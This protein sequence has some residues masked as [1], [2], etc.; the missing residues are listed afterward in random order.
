MKKQVIIFIKTLSILSILIIIS[1][2]P[3]N[4]SSTPK[5]SDNTITTQA[6]IST[7]EYKKE[8][9]QL[10]NSQDD[11]LA[12]QEK[13]YPIKVGS[14]QFQ[15]LEDGSKKIVKDSKFGFINKEG[16]MKIPPIYDIANNFS[17]ELALV[18]KDTRWG[19]IDKKSNIIIDMENAVSCR[20]FSEG[21]AC[22]IDSIS[23]LYG[24]I[25]NNGATVIEPK[26][27]Y[28]GDFHDGLSLVC[29]GQGNEQYFFYIDSRGNDVFNKIYDKYATS[30]ENGFAVNRKTVNDQVIRYVLDTNGNE[31][32][33]PE[34][35]SISGD[36]VLYN[37]TIQ[38]KN[39]TDG[40]S[41]FW[42]L[43]DGS[44]TSVNKNN[45]NNEGGDNPPI[46]LT[47]YRILNPDSDHII[48]QDLQTYKYG[49]IDKHGNFVLQCE[50]EFI[51]AETD[52]IFRF[53]NDEAFGLININAQII[54]EPNF[55]ELS[56]FDENGMAR[57]SPRDGIN[58]G[59]VTLDG[60]I[61]RGGDYVE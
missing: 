61:Y 2:S 26:Y 52:T 49:V 20:S 4:L 41:S 14:R 51:S 59:Y 56:T 60:R 15:T 7:E 19:Y 38:V 11:I 21:L 25:D 35:Y 36:F 12:Y 31:L 10:D 58:G 1:C 48:T 18:Q 34:D 32:F 57:F 53:M 28:A 3:G 5:S 8:N 40:G 46:D 22:F 6:D 43:I 29:H 39:K 47:K 17:E 44:I 24:Y 42:S 54:L 9:L 45:N 13:L 50:Y 33:P 16:Q 23:G 27:T 37:K 55:Y 30:F